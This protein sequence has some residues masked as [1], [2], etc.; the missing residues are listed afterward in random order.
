MYV[1]QQK[2]CRFNRLGCW[3]TPTIKV[4]STKVWR[5]SNSR[6]R[7]KDGFKL[8]QPKLQYIDKHGRLWTLNRDYVWDGASYP[9]FLERFIG[10]KEKDAILAAS[11]FHDIMMLE[12]SL[13]DH[14]QRHITVNLSVLEAARLY[15]EMKRDWPYKDE[16]PNFLKRVVQKLGLII[17]QPLYNFFTKGTAWYEYPNEKRLDKQTII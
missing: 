4:E 11:A 13:I 1:V 6:S 9:G 7:V 15:K 16:K 2:I 12:L 14:K 17:F 3:I 8:K 10:K 5:G